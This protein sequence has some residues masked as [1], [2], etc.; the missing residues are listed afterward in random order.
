[1]FLGFGFVRA[2]LYTAC[3]PLGALLFFN[4]VASY[5]KK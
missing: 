3:V 4:K 5:K 2:L 1:L